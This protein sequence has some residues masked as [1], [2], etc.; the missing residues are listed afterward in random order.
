VCVTGS[1]ERW[2][3]E[4]TEETGSFRVT[5]RH[6]WEEQQ[7]MKRLLQKVSDQLPTVA[8][9][10]ELH[11]RETAEILK[12]HESRLR[13]VEQRLWKVFGAIALIAGA[14]P[15]LARLIP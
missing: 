15:F 10:L 5:M 2:E 4:V 12:D 11:E 8:Q 7:E 9:K 6:V 1:V 14:T 13:Q 3:P